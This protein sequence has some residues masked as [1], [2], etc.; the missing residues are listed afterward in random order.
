MQLTK[1]FNLSEFKSK[2]GS[3]FPSH[4]IIDNIK[5]LAENLQVIRDYVGVPI[6]I[7]SGY[8]SPEHNKAIGGKKESFH[9]KGMASDLSCEIGPEKLHEII[10]MLMVRRKIKHG[11]HKAY[12]TFVHYDIRGWLATW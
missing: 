7:N 1:N 5:E 11:G 3:E 8:R 10:Y 12:N 9:L 2:D 6:S 4:V